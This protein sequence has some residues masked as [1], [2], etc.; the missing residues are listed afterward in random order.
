MMDVLK[1]SLVEEARTARANDIVFC[2]AQ[3]PFAKKSGP[4]VVN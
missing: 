1:A 4:P 3:P 2:F